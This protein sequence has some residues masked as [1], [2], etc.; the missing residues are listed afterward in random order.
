MLHLWQL[1]IIWRW[2]NFIILD[3]ID[4][5]LVWPMCL[6]LLI[7][8]FECIDLC[9]WQLLITTTGKQRLYW[10]LSF[11]VSRLGEL[12]ISIDLCSVTTVEFL[13][14]QVARWHF[15][16]SVYCSAPHPGF[17]SYFNGIS[18]IDKHLWSGRLGELQNTNTNATI[19]HEFAVN[20]LICDKWWCPAHVLIFIVPPFPITIIHPSLPYHCYPPAV[21][22]HFIGGDFQNAKNI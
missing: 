8:V 22:L 10:S 6:S 21:N 5:I 17:S 15:Y 9:E 4:F 12:T 7:S 16:W 20:L 3:W 18:M 2:I 14:H 13:Q 11:E 1:L 19:F